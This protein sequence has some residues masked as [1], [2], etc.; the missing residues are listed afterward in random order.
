MRSLE[1]GL[2][3]LNILSRELEGNRKS[4]L[5]KFVDDIIFVLPLAGRGINTNN[6]QAAMQR[7]L[8]CLINQSLPLMMFSFAMFSS[9]NVIMYMATTHAP[10]LENE[11]QDA[12]SWRLWNYKCNDSFKSDADRSKACVIPGCMNREE[13]G[14]IEENILFQHSAFIECICDIWIK[15][16]SLF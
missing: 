9:L 10:Q 13:G 1:K 3:L 11:A 7:Y 6:I 16:K 12:G 5:I 8:G 15:I 2:N 14:R 4:L